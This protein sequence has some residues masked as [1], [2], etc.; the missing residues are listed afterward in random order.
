MPDVFAGV[1][2]LSLFLL[3]FA[4]L[5]I[6]ER[7]ALAAISALGVSGH[8]SLLPIAAL[9][10][11]A[12]AVVR[13][14]RPA[15]QNALSPTHALVWLTVPLIVA[16]LWTANLNRRMGLGFQLSLSTNDFLFG[17]LLNDGLAP[18]FLRANCPARP[19]V[20][21]RYLVSL[22]R[23]P[24]EFLFWHPLR[25]AMSPD[26]ER[27][28][29][30]GTLGAYPLRFAWASTRHTLRQLVQFRTGD[31]VRALELH[32]V[33]PNGV[34]IMETFP[35]D[36]EPYAASKLIRGRL[37]SLT[38]IVARIDT[39]VFWLCAIGC[40]TLAFSRRDEEWNRFFYAAVLFLVLNAAVCAT[41]AGVYDRYQ[42]RVAWIIPLCLAIFVCRH[43]GRKQNNSNLHANP[44]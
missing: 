20:V 33:N 14:A 22:P 31:E 29:V 17:R 12:L 44:W 30:R 3:A 2:F 15:A 37:E 7:I 16:G 40:A 21:C 23:T 4:K 32:A 24:E 25:A 5:N 35:Q 36:V 9:F 18:D 38:R 27:Q 6:L 13:F 42:A 11:I 41:F 34:A 26:E 8:S 10:V 39:A 43:L 28:I 19:F 1:V